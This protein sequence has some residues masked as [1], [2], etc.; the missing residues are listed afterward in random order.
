MAFDAPGD[1]GSRIWRAFDSDDTSLPISSSASPT[2]AT[3]Q[4]SHR[5]WAVASFPLPAY[6]TPGRLLGQAL[7]SPPSID[8]ADRCR[9]PEQERPDLTER[10]RA[11][12]ARLFNASPGAAEPF[13]GFSGG[14]VIVAGTDGEHLIGIVKEG[15]D[16]YGEQRAF[17]TSWDDFV[18]AF[19]RSRAWRQLLES[20]GHTGS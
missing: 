1:E 11:F 19:T 3:S 14:P 16:I 8:P 17:A 10:E 2:S 5:K 9:K 20:R 18:N 12:A 4:T 15:R 7:D 13:G 6:V